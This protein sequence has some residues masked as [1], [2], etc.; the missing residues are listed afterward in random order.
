MVLTIIFLSDHLGSPYAD[1]EGTRVYPK[2]EDKSSDF[3]W[4]VIY[5]EPGC[6]A[7]TEP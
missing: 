2:L 1:L 5:L 3:I 7:L 6:I 4:P